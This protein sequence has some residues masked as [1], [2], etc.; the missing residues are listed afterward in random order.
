MTRQLA[1][2]H[3]DPASSQKGPVVPDVDRYEGAVVFSGVA[4]ALG[5]PTEF[6]S[7]KPR[8][9]PAFRLPVHTFVSW[10]KMVGGRWWG[11][12]DKIGAG[13][14]S[15][16]TQLALAVARSISDTGEFEPERFAYEELPLWLH[17]QRGGGR[18]MK[19]AARG[20]IRRRADWLRNF[21]RQGQV[22]YR[23][24]GA[25]G[26]AMRALPIALAHGDDESAVVRDAFLNA[27][28]THGH[29]RG[30]LG[31]ILFALAVHHVL[32]QA[33]GE[34]RKTVVDYLRDLVPSLD[35]CSA[36]DGRIS[37]WVGARSTRGREENESFQGLFEGV[38]EETRGYLGAIAGGESDEPQRYYGVVGGLSPATKGSGIGTVCCALYLYAR[39]GEQPEQAIRTAA[40]MLGSDTDTIGVFLGALLGAEWGMEGIPQHLADGI[41]DRGYLVRTAQRLHSIMSGERAE[42][43]G[44]GTPVGREEA[45][46]RILAWEIG[47]HEMFWDALGEGARLIHPTLGRGTVVKRRVHDIGREGYVAKLLRVAFDCGQACVFHSRVKDD[48]RVSES[49]AE[50]LQKALPQ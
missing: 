28:I 50:Q 25:N 20:L 40:N 14:Y 49:L 38:R 5:W 4:D 35:R 8:R 47:L 19:A 23:N 46:L 21:Y 27:L 29:P 43:A 24:A 9:R 15:D 31:A 7:P 18:S 34:G 44:T 37:Q 13:E 6:L 1:F 32:Q 36:L 16:D 3:D 10:T 33:P 22:D 41:Q 39:S 17:Y 48:L 26:A 45:Y 11:Y 2:P 30:L 42:Q 12:P